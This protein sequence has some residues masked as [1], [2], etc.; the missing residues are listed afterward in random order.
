MGAN[1][2]SLPP[3]ETGLLVRSREEMITLKSQKAYIGLSELMGWVLRVTNDKENNLSSAQQFLALLAC[4]KL[5]VARYLCFLK[6][7]PT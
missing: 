1:S 5:F 2:P 6:S 3:D 7:Y 4:D